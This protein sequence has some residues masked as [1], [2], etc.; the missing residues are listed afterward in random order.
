[1]LLR[2][3]LLLIIHHLGASKALPLM[4]LPF[5]GLFKIIYRDLLING[6]VNRQ[7]LWDRFKQIVEGIVEEAVVDY[8]VNAIEEGRRAVEGAKVFATE[9]DLYLMKKLAI[10]AANPEVYGSV[11]SARA[12][13]ELMS[14]IQ[15]GYPLA[16]PGSLHET[17]YN[18]FIRLARSN[19]A[20][21]NITICTG[22][23]SNLSAR[24]SPVIRWWAFRDARVNGL[25]GEVAPLLERKTEFVDTA[26]FLSQGQIREV[27]TVSGSSSY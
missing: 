16:L 10:T 2:A 1:V 14:A 15:S 17:V 20:V 5:T 23:E 18:E 21:S 11:A 19:G 12:A 26:P 6:P 9:R 27:T 8:T 4:A 7:T 22:D 3:L 13:E 25:T 24:V